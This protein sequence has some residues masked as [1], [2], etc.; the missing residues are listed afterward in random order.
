MRFSTSASVTG[1]PARMASQQ[2]IMP[3]CRRSSSSSRLRRLSRSARDST[4]P[5]LPRSWSL[6]S[7]SVML[8][9]DFVVRRLVGY[10]V[11][12]HRRLRA[13]VYCA[14][15]L[16]ANNREVV[17]DDWLAVLG[18]GGLGVLALQQNCV[19]L[20]DREVLMRRPQ[21]GADP[22]GVRAEAR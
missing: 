4:S 18:A 15:V 12:V 13:R 20:G 1:R 8:E 9:R 10:G 3:S 19:V 11:L 2:A 6:S 16:G 7:R 5:A 21:G 14:E 22:H 17:V